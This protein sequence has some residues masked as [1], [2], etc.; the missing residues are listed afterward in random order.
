M[1]FALVVASGGGRDSKFCNTI[2]PS[3][4]VLK[5]IRAY[6]QGIEGR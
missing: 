4:Y 5:L 3:L 1:R 6:D 2:C